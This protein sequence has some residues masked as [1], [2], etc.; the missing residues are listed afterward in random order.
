MSSQFSHNFYYYYTI[1]D[2]WEMFSIYQRKGILFNHIPQ[3]AYSIETWEIVI[4][5]CSKE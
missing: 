3:N 2:E 5:I 4:Q 1:T